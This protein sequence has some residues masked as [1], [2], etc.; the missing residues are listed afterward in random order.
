M[1][2]PQE[3]MHTRRIINGSN[4]IVDSIKEIVIDENDTYN[5]QR[6]ICIIYRYP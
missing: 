6:E 4:K 1:E 2:Y 5:P 3:K